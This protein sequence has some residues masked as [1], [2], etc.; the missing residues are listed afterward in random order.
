M[1]LSLFIFFILGFLTHSLKLHLKCTPIY[2]PSSYPI[3]GCLISFYKNRHRLLDWY[4][5]LLSESPTQTILV[6]RFGAP[7]TIIT[8]NPDNVEYMLKTN[9]INYPKGKP[10][11]DIL[12][13]F[14]GRGIFNVDG[15]L[16]SAQRKLTS[17]E[18]S[19]NSLREF[20]VKTLEEV[21]ENR[22][23][24]LLIQAAKSGK[25]LDL[26]DVL[27]R[28]AFDTICKVSLGTDPHC[29]DDLSHVPV[30]VDS[31]DTASQACAMRGMA[32]VYAIWKSKRA[33][34]LGSEKKL[35]ENVKRVHC[36]IDE[37]IQEKKLK[38][39]TE[40]GGDHMKNT[41]LL[42]RLLIA[43][44][45]NEVV[46]DMVISFLMAGRDTTSSALTWLFWL[47][48]NHRDVKDEMIKEITSINNGNKSLDFDELKE[49]KYL[50]ACLNESMRLYP[51]VV[52]DSKHAAKD[53]VLPDGTR[54]QK[55]N[56]V[57]YFQYGM[58]RMEEIWGKDRLEF[59]P[60][61]WMDENGAL[62]IV[63]PYKFPVF[64]AGPRVCLGK[65]MAFTQMKYVLA[66]VLR[67]FDIKPVVNVEKPV[68][69]PLLTA[70]MAGG[71]NVRI[72][73]RN[74]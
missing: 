20:V 17:H 2:G 59:K 47:T 9:F 52:W 29:L 28:F 66:S 32:P 8:A 30:L 72:Y 41:D 26:Q 56:R 43:G 42:S 57:T 64:Q 50:A 25:V 22:L 46:R 49:M 58:G 68:F 65:E 44:H 67:R 63:N 10:F 39:A 54:V 71:F 31:F 13:D 11:T 24:P 37:I 19:T 36:C 35:K 7:R 3:L 73:H 15:E 53:D 16:W 69:I 4:T 14:L 12:G 33:L 21:V 74:G 27:R 5:Q 45:E 70:H 1:F 6:Q 48:T 60:D 61:R 38:I 18:F 62:K 34:N 23:T 51:P 55:G 40:N